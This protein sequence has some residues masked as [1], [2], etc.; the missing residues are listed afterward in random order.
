M[1]LIVLGNNGSFPGK[2][3]ACPGYLLKGDGFNILIDC[4]N[5]V[6]SRMQRYCKIEELDAIILSHLHKDHISDMYVLK[7]ALLSKKAMG[8]PIPP[9]NVFLPKSPENEFNALN[10]KQYFTLRTLKDNLRVSIK[11]VKMEFL[12]V[13]HS[14]ET[15]GIRIEYDGKV[16]SY[17]SDT[18]FTEKLYPIALN[19]D[20]FLCESTLTEKYRGKGKP[21]HMFAAEAAQVAKR[22]GVKKLLLT[23]FWHEE[24]RSNYLGESKKVF[25]NTLVSEEFTEYEI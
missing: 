15:Y 23:H 25:Q 11:G 2:D 17:S 19:S 9:I 10:D 8:K 12:P 14:V 1:K 4:G 5:G 18:I 13:D 24:E 6:L 7:Y 3:G 16:L 22:C 21:V 20:I